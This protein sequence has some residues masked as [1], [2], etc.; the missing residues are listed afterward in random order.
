MFRNARNV[1]NDIMVVL[2]GTFMSSPICI[3]MITDLIYKAVFRENAKEYRVVLRLQNEENVRHTLYAEVLL[4]I[5]SFENG[6]AHQIEKRYSENRNKLLTCDNSRSLS[7]LEDN[8]GHASWYT[9]CHLRHDRWLLQ[10]QYQVCE[11]G[12]V[13]P[14]RSPWEAFRCSDARQRT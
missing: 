6:V 4:C 9:W 12:V 11:Y 13:W 5:S 10:L 8:H 14:F 1:K 2:V 7:L 3:L